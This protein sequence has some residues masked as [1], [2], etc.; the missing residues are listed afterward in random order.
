MYLVVLEPGQATLLYDDPSHNI[1]VVVANI[2]SI[3]YNHQGS[4]L[5]HTASI[6]VLH[7]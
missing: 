4:N 5:F 3:P 2:E 7:K 6:F 1:D